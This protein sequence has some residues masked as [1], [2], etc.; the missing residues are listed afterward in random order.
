MDIKKLQP[1]NLECLDQPTNRC[2]K[3]W[4]QGFLTL[5]QPITDIGFFFANAQPFSH[6]A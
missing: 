3:L 1:V 2:V 5:V 4:R 6:F